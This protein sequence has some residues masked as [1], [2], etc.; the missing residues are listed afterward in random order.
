MARGSHAAHPGGSSGHGGD[1]AAGPNRGPAAPGSAVQASGGSLHFGGESGRATRKADGALAP[2]R[3]PDAR[4]GTAE[5]AGGPGERAHAGIGAAP[6]TQPA[7][8]DPAGAGRGGA[9][10][11]GARGAGQVCPGRARRGAA[12]PV[13]GG[14]AARCL[15]GAERASP[16]D[17]AVECGGLAAGA[18]CRRA[19]AGAA[20]PGGYRPT[21]SGAIRPSPLVHFTRTSVPVDATPSSSLAPPPASSGSQPSLRAL[22]GG[23]DHPG[24]QAVE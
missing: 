7:G 18:C 6:G 22:R 24:R 1:A 19:G 12:D 21:A 8:V 4:P 9:A 23:A 16:R 11:G 10:D 17:G 3:S 14:W 13:R 2:G 20:P 5:L 15:P